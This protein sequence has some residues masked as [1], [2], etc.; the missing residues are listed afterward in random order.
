MRLGSLL[1]MASTAIAASSVVAQP[2]RP[3]VRTGRLEQQAHIR[4]HIRDAR[5]RSA[6]LTAVGRFG[7]AHRELQLPAAGLRERLA[8]RSSRRDLERTMAAGLT[9]LDNHGFALRVSEIATLP[10]SRL[11]RRM[12]DRLRRELGRRSRRAFEPDRWLLSVPAAEQRQRRSRL[13]EELVAVFTPRE[14]ADPW[15]GTN[16]SIDEY[17][18]MGVYEILRTLCARMIDAQNPD[19]DEWNRLARLAEA[20]LAA[21]DSVSAGWVM[22]A[23]VRYV[24]SREYSHWSSA[25][26]RAEGL[27]DRMEANPEAAEALRQVVREFPQ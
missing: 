4:P 10:V 24:R 7:D 27:A 11:R 8:L 3:S 23:A 14:F 18:R 5:T 6:R 20:T 19:Y 21:G 2:P 12:V 26:R 16:F 15:R 13:L 9:P 22:E 25:L 1:L 17:H